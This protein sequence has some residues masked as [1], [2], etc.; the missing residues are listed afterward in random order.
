MHL[1]SDYASIEQLSILLDVEKAYPFSIVDGY[2][3]GEVFVNDLADPTV[4]LFWHH[5]GFAFIAGECNRVFLDEVH[6]M[7]LNPTPEH[8]NRMIVQARDLS[9]FNDYE[10]VTRY[11][12]YTFSLKKEAPELVVPEGCELREIT[13][14][15][16]DK[17]EARIRP[18]DY[19][20]D[21]AEFSKNGFGYML[22]QGDEILAFAFSAAV[23]NKRVDIGVD[24]FEKYREHGYGKVVAA[25][26][27]QEINRQHKTPV[28]A[29]IE[30]NEASHHLACAIGFDIFELHPYYKIQ[31]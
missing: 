4:A 7:M 8:C 29:C 21:A 25:A 2:Q 9:L 22:T 23:S 30:E 3:S 19:W 13:A 10:D 5:S 27:V 14:D 1:I 17:L 15:D 28:W 16:F 11:K 6:E 18:A 24:T 12:R 20:K 26:M 31:K